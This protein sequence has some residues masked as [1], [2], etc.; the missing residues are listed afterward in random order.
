MASYRPI[1]SDTTPADPYGSA[2]AKSIMASNAMLS[3]G[4]RRFPEE[5][6]G[7]LFSI[8]PQLPLELS[9]KLL[10]LEQRLDKRKRGLRALVFVQAVYV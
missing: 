9:G 8:G 3:S 4:L 6:L 7:S 10:Y 5:V 2:G 1:G